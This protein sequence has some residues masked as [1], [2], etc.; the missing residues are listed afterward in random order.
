MNYKAYTDN[1]KRKLNLVELYDNCF[2]DIVEILSTFNFKK[3]FS[4]Q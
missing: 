2:Q 4:L 1:K 3:E